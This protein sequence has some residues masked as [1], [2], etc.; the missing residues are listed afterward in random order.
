VVAGA[1]GTRRVVAP[2]LEVQE[3]AATPTMTVRMTTTSTGMAMVTTTTTET[4]KTPTMM[5]EV[6]ATRFCT[7]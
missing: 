2:S 1:K 4:V 5:N 3:V 7:S 6:P